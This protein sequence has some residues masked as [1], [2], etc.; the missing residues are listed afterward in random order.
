MS[1][2]IKRFNL[3]FLVASLCLP[4]ATQAQQQPLQESQIETI[5]V[6][7]EKTDRSLQETSSS[8][9]V[10]TAL[11]IEQENLQSLDDILNRTA[12]VSAM[13]GSRGFTIRG[14]ADEAG[15]VGFAIQ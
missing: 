11:R 5:T 1:L 6:R 4:L 14:I 7:G 3:S 13:Y 10:T 9:A 2:P 8:V 12:N 15:A